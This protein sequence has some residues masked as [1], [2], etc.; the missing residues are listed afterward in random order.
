L[1]KDRPNGL[2]LLIGKLKV[3]HARFFTAYYFYK[4]ELLDTSVLG[5]NAVPKDILDNMKKFP[6]YD[7]IN[8]Y[9]KIITC[10]GPADTVSIIEETSEGR[11][12]A[13]GGWPFDP[14][15]FKNS[16]ITYACETY[17]VDRPIFNLLVTEK[18]YRAVV[19]KHPFI[20]QSNSGQLNTIK[21]LGFETFSSIIDESYNEYELLDY[22]HV[23]K[24]VLAAKDFLAKIPNNVDKVQE[25]VD[26]N[27]KHWLTRAKDEYDR[28]HSYLNNFINNI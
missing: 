9:N 27:Y 16:S 26:Y 3:K 18:T 5:I 20:V 11:T 21:S 8:F 14:E 15:I 6:K 12:A 25:I 10:L 13:A 23:E 28:T 2:N 19:N 1:V 4:H 22:S 24:T 7:D 17:D